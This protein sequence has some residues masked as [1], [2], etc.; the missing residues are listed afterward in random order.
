MKPEHI[1]ALFQ[2]IANQ[3]ETPDIDPNIL[4]KL[5]KIV[6]KL[7]KKELQESDAIKQAFQLFFPDE[8]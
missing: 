1:L 2:K 3:K 4:K 6:E 7:E 5:E 8:E